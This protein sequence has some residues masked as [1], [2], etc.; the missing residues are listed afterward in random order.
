MSGL[1]ALLAFFEKAIDFLNERHELLRVL[2]HTGKLAEFDP[3]FFLWRIHN[4]GG[5]GED[6][7]SVS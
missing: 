1:E 4:R 6:A 5:L 7:L 2:F 3:S